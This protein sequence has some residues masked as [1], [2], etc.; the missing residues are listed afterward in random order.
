MIKR[1]GRNTL[2]R[3]FAVGDI[4]GCYS[5]LQAALE[6]VGF[7]RKSDRLFSIGD[8]VDR[9]AESERVHDLLTHVTC[10]GATPIPSIIRS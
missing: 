1:F 9:G 2:G 10:S 7:C 8:L 5:R 4:H 6:T 3:D